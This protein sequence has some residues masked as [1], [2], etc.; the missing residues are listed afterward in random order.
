MFG[1]QFVPFL[2]WSSVWP[3]QDLN[4][5]PTAWEEEDK[6]YNATLCLQN[7]FQ[8]F[9]QYIIVM[10]NKIWTSLDVVFQYYLMTLLHV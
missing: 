9:F 7:T 3:G 6:L 5:W 8:A 2:W 1:R 10:W 4:P